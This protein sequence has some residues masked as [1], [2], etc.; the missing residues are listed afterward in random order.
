LQ[1]SRHQW[2]GFI[3]SRYFGGALHDFAGGPRTKSALK[4]TQQKS[5]ERVH[6]HVNHTFDDYV[7]LIG[8][9]G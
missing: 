7:V 1:N 2:Y 3:K 9:A 4:V 6:N 5:R 8:A